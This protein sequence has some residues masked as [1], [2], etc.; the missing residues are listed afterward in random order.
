MEL[1]ARRVVVAVVQATTV[2]VAVGLAWMELGVVEVPPSSTLQVH[3][4]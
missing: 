3:E 1:V 4:Q 2:V